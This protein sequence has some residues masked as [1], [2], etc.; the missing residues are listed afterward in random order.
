MW[1][2]RVPGL[3]SVQLKEQIWPLREPT[4]RTTSASSR[5]VFAMM[6]RPYWPPVEV[7]DP[8]ADGT[9]HLFDPRNEVWSEHFRWDGYQVVGLTAVGRATVFAL[10]LNHPRRLLIRRAEELFGLFPPT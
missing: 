8:E 7:P 5:T 3:G 2:T 9:T 1:M 10:D 4:I 6:P